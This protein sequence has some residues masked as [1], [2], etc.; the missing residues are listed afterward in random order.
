MKR[1]VVRGRFL[2][3]TLCAGILV[4][5]VIAIF[6]FPSREEIHAKNAKE[7][8]TRAGSVLDSALLDSSKCYVSV[9]IDE[10]ALSAVADSRTGQW[11]VLSASYIF[12]SGPL[13]V[14]FKKKSCK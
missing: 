1:S 6:T 7:S 14:L 9:R 2:W 4:G 10:D 12:N 3:E 11:D 5:V 8:A 13:Q